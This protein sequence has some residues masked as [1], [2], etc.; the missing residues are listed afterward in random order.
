M[1]EDCS[2][3]CVHGKVDG[4]SCVCDPCYAGAGCELECSGNGQCV[5][6]TCDC[7]STVIGIGNLI[8]N[9]DKY[10]DTFIYHINLPFRV[11]HIYYRIKNT[12]IQ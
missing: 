5:N 7:Y 8:K 10:F 1:G 2:K 12:C 6:K 11:I 3:P 9:D 4:T